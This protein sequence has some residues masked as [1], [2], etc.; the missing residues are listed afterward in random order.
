VVDERVKFFRRVDDSGS[1]NGFSGQKREGIE[2]L[3]AMLQTNQPISSR[4]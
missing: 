3:F 1:T 4:P 2:K